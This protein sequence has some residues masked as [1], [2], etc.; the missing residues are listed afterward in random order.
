[1]YS[2]GAVYEGSW[3]NGCINGYGKLFYASNKI[4]YEGE[5]RNDKFHGRGTI[6]N[7]EIYQF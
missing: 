5:W 1:M 2:D 3:V 6:Y 4:A 7:E